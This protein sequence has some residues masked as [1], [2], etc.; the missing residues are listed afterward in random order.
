MKLE[1]LK[2]SDLEEGSQKGESQTS[3]EAVLS[4][5][6]RCPFSLEEG[7]HRVGNQTSEGAQAGLC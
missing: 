6:C 5:W 2:F 1:L 7:P 4:G 3:N